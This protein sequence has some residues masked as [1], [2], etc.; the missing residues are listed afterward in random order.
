MD[1][2]AVLY[3][4]NFF[5]RDQ[6]SAKTFSGIQLQP[7]VTWQEGTYKA[8]LLANLSGSYGNGEWEDEFTLME[9]NLSWQ[10]NPKMYLSAGKTLVRWGKGYAW[11]PVN[12][13]GRDK[14]PS[15]PDLVLEGYWMALADLV[16][17]FPGS[18][19]TFAVTAVALPVNN[20]INEEFGNGDELNRAAKLYFLLHDTDIDLL[21]LCDGSLTERYGLD[22]S[23]NI[24]S[25]FEIHGEWAVVDDFV[26]PIV[27][28]DGSRSREQ[29]D[30]QSYLLGIRYLAPTDTTFIVEYYHNGQGYTE[31]EIGDFF[32][33]IEVATAPELAAL[34]DTSGSYQQPSSMQNYF[35]LRTSQKEPF[36]WLYFSPAL[37]SMVNLDD[38]SYN[39]IPE[40]AYTG[41]TNL[42]LRLRINMLSGNDGTEY[43]EKQ[44]NSKIEVRARYFF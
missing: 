8:F 6:D 16:F 43:G 35:Y 13:V 17:S 7:E 20:G 10:A 32:D 44:S 30:A 12:F 18:L 14:N 15:D 27:A 5:D 34:R 36:G 25:N 41:V 28:S 3:R 19:K 37:T 39:I 4:L 24:T 26:K 2:D 29:F 22:F 42:E 21:Y 40:V 1:R 33:F 9:G 31:D 38:G 11:N 23:R